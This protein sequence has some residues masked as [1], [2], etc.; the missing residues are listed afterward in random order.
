MST[1]DK[2]PLCADKEKYAVT[3]EDNSHNNNANDYADTKDG[4][5]INANNVTFSQLGHWHLD[6]SNINNKNM[7]YLCSWIDGELV[8]MQSPYENATTLWLVWFDDEPNQEIEI[9]FFSDKSNQEPC[10]ETDQTDIEAHEISEETDIDILIADLNKF[11]LFAELH[12]STVL[13]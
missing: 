5:H 8:P 7:S 3:N 2:Q 10:K 6:N 12:I 11:C 1:E 4:A 9:V 13:L